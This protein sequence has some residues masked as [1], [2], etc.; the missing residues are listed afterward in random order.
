MACYSP[1]VAYKGGLTASGKQ[2]IL[3]RA[4]S[5][6]ERLSL[7]CGKCVGCRLAYSKGWAI[8]CLHEAQMW[9]DNCFVTLTFDD[10]HLPADSCL[11]KS[12]VSEFMR[13]LRRVSGPGVRFFS[14]GEYGG[15][16]GRPH[17]H[18]LIFNYDFPDKVI[19]RE[20]LGN[21]FFTSKVLGELWPFGFHSISDV[22]MASAAYVARY[23]VKKADGTLSSVLSMKDEVTG[24]AFWVDR[25]SGEM[26]TPE[27]T[28]MSRRPGIGA[29][30]FD[31][32][33]SDVYPSDVVVVS[34][35]KSKPPRFY[36]YLLDKVDPDLLESLKLE[37]SQKVS[38]SESCLDRLLV[39]EEVCLS[40]LKSKVRSL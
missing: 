14:A 32:Y 28:L 13:E 34:G 9:A 40:G 33:S 19:E 8:R 21:R 20:R 36:D 3:W 37:R 26:R 12:H 4:P 39:R 23:C 7:P 30:W 15:K 11:S 18:I 35:V 25:V 24:D 17:Y 16:F 6:T 10:D 38:W 29:K 31:R 1:L 2:E 22:T 5:G 27:F